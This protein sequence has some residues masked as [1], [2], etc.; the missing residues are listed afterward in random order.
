MTRISRPSAAR[1]LA[2]ARRDARCVHA[3]SA[4][5]SS[6][7]RHSSDVRP[8]RRRPPPASRACAVRKAVSGRDTLVAQAGAARARAAWSAARNSD[9]AHP[10]EDGE[11]MSSRS[12]LMVPVREW[13]GA[14]LRAPGSTRP[15]ELA[16]DRLSGLRLAPIDCFRSRRCREVG[17][18]PLNV[19]SQSQAPSRR[20]ATAVARYGR[21]CTSPCRIL[22]GSAACID[23]RDVALDGDAT[24]VPRHDERAW[25]LRD[26]FR[27]RAQARGT[28]RLFRLGGAPERDLASSVNSR[29]IA[30]ASPPPAAWSSA[31]NAVSTAA[32]SL[33]TSGG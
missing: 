21:V 8:A 29:T 1:S 16:M 6:S 9:S 10:V 14:I 33:V 2:R 31:S 23:P 22:R 20:T 28:D 17:W 3:L 19:M 12:S 24:L 27:E 18:N 7:N 30:S 26:R 11:P 32:T 13:H 4:A 25:R 15:S 5:L